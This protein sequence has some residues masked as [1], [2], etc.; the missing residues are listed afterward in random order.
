MVISTFGP[1]SNHKARQEIQYN[2]VSWRIV[3]SF[4]WR[5]W[6]WHLISK[7]HFLFWLLYSYNQNTDNHL[8]TLFILPML[9]VSIEQ[10]VLPSREM[11]ES[12]NVLF[13]KIPYTSGFESVS[14]ASRYRNSPFRRL[15]RNIPQA[16]GSARTLWGWHLILV[17]DRVL[18]PPMGVTSRP[19]GQLCDSDVDAGTM[20]APFSVPRV[21]ILSRDLSWICVD[22]SKHRLNEA[23]MYFY[24]SLHLKTEQIKPSIPPTRC[25]ETF[26]KNGPPTTNYKL[27]MLIMDMQ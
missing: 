21:F 5:Y 1:T 9:A 17:I 14:V 18:L 23:L 13:I 19:K 6:F 16:W 25:Q 26:I 22:V 15:K 2:S 3:F 8:F 24:R 10:I 20:A 27:C 4:N 11:A 12:N 7:C